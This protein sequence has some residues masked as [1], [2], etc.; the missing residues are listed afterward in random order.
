[1]SIF[2]YCRGEHDAKNSPGNLTDTRLDTEVTF[3]VVY[4]DGDM[5]DMTFP[6]FIFCFKAVSHPKELLNAYGELRIW[7]VACNMDR[8]KTIPLIPFIRYLTNLGPA[9]QS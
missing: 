5:E 9:V 3:H 8:P 2:K 6:E 4:E 7:R 1:M